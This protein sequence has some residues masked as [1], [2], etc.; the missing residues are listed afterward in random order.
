MIYLDNGATTLYKPKE[1]GEEILDALEGGY[2]NPG[3]SS[4]GPSLKSLRKLYF[5]RRE[6]SDTFG[7][8]APNK[9]VLNPGIT[10][11]L[12]LVLPS[13]IRPGDHVLTSVMEHNSVLRPLYQLE[14]R[15][16][17]LS[18][19]PME[20]GPVPDENMVREN[21]KFLVLT[22]AS[23]VLGYAPDLKLWSEFAEKHNLIFIVDGAQALGTIPQPIDEIENIIYCF[24][25][26]KGLHGPTGTGGMIIKGDYP[27]TPVFSGGSGYHSFEK[28]QPGDLPGIFEP[29]TLPFHGLFGLYGGIKAWKREENLFEKLREFR[30]IFYKGLSEIPKIKVYGS[31][32]NSAP[33]VSCNIEKIPSGEVADRLW[34]DFKIAV[35]GGSHCAPKVHEYLGT[36]EQGA[37]RFSFSGNN[38]KEELYQALNAM[39][40]LAKKMR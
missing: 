22:A 4:G 2:G 3:R 17:E 25:G 11:S 29:G 15:G 6:I 12:N 9:T 10:W 8:E 34:D 39:E 19:L 30:D 28:E 16:V 21:T 1:V 36:V 38:T 20:E 24:T 27:F 7:G 18:F 5:L 37:V 23:N 35:R 32:K 33:V 31:C 40:D 13:L 26:H 14:K